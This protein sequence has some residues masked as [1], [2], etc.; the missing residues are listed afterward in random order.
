MLLYWEKYPA[1]DFLYAP[2]NVEAEDL[3]D[4]VIW[5]DNFYW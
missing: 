4:L 3:G 5:R 1:R 2:Q